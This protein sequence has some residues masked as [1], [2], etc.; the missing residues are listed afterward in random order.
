MMPAFL[1]AGDGKTSAMRV[2]SGMVVFSVMAV[3]IAHN[4]VAMVKGSGFISMGSSEAMLIAAA[5]GAKAAQHFGESRG[6]VSSTD[7]IPT[8]NGQ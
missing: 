7:E 6:K 5:L 1:Q 4:V 2:F 8:G 3:F